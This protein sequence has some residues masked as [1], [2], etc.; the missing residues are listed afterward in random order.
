MHHR[1]VM[2]G[3]SATTWRDSLSL[4]GFTVHSGFIQFSI[5]QQTIGQLVQN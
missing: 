4:S 2:C 3:Q 1:Y 5:R